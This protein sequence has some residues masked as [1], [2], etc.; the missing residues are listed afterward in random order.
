LR[1]RS[2]FTLGYTATVAVSEDHII[3]AQ[4]VTQEPTDNDALVPMVE[5]VSQQC[6]EKSARVSANSG[7]F[8][9]ENLKAMEETGI[10]A[11]IPDTNLARVLN[12]GGRLRQ[13]A[14]APEHRRMRRKLRDPA[15]RRIYQDI[16]KLDCESV[17]AKLVQMLS[18]KHSRTDNRPSR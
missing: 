16:P 12:R 8:S 4:R 3:L 1:E 9:I 13:H 11:Y 2:G 7:F 5:A 17:G 15:A 6:R 14:V 10:D 18:P